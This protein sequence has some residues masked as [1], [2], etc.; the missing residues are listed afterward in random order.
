MII[1]DILLCILGVLIAFLI[2]G[3]VIMLIVKHTLKKYLQYNTNTELL[4]LSENSEDGDSKD[5]D[6]EHS[7]LSELSDHSEHSERN[8]NKNI[9]YVGIKQMRNK[10]SY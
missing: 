5:N 2:V 3:I 4:E 6:L 8:L 9:V 10:K 1:R 7:E